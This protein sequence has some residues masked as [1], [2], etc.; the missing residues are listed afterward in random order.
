MNKSGATEILEDDKEE[1]PGLFN[2]ETK[3]LSFYNNDIKQKKRIEFALDN[4]Y[5]RKVDRIY[6]FVYK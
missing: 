6:K 1:L 5:S 3:N 4:T 2:T